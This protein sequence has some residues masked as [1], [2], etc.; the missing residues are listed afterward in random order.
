MAARSKRARAT[1]GAAIIVAAVALAAAALA[2]SRLNSSEDRNDQ[3]LLGEA[4]SG[5]VRVE[6]GS[7]VG[8]IKLTEAAS[9]GRPIV[10]LDA[11][12]GGRDPGAKGVSGS[13]EKELTLALARELRT[14]L[15]ERGRVRVALTREDDRYLTLDQR[16]EIAR[17]LGA[18]AYLSLH[19]DSAPNPLA[20]GATV[21]SLSDVASD[22]EA[23]RLA[24]KENKAG[25]GVSSEPDGS[26]R[27]MLSDLALREQMNASASLAERLVR[28]SAGRYL[29]RPEPHRFADF[30]VLRHAEVPAV[31]FEAGY[32][33]N[34]DDEAL[35]VQV[36]ERARI[37]AALAQAIEADVASRN[38]R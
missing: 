36:K 30:R 33:S 6:L 23:A 34:V 10:V 4:R 32:I 14:E 22:A 25:E 16:A 17:R 26:V 27:G 12:H 38:V 19:I 20:R 13:S 7:A 37:V 3:V 18:S 11:G 21:Y 35:L 9:P 24:D 31:L 2:A 8:E 29:L 15:A 5:A 28:K 1:A